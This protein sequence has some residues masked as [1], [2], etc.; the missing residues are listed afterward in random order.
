MKDLEQKVANLF[1]DNVALKT[2]LEARREVEKQQYKEI[3]R[4][5]VQLVQAVKD[6]VN[7]HVWDLYCVYL[8]YA[9]VLVHNRTWLLKNSH[10][11]GP[12]SHSWRRRL[13]CWKN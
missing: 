12:G 13:S 7:V 8:F 6:L 3:A 1:M 5:K 9:H 4:L 10:C 11:Q 2:M